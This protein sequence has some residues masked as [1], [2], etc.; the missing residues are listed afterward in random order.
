MRRPSV[1]QAL[2]LHDRRCAACSSGPRRTRRAPAERSRSPTSRRRRLVRAPRRTTG[3]R[4]PRARHRCHMREVAACPCLRAAPARRPSRTRH[5]AVRRARAAVCGIT[6]HP[7][8]S[9]GPAGPSRT[10]TPAVHDDSDT[11]CSVS[12]Q[13]GFGDS[14]AAFRAC[15]AGRG[16]SSPARAPA[17]SPCTMTTVIAS[18]RIMSC[19]ASAVPR[20]VPVTFERPTRGGTRQEPRRR[21]SPPPPLGAPSRAANRSADP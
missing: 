8:G 4:V 13:R 10:S 19:T 11:A 5:R 6:S 21:S 2:V 3:R 14:R 15:T 16:G 17:P 12:R 1:P 20:T 9:H 18:T 7:A